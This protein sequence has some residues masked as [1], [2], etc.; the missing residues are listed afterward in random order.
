MILTAAET[1]A[2]GELADKLLDE[3]PD[4]SLELRL[5]RIGVLAHAIPER[6]RTVLTQFRING[7]PYGGFVISG[8][9]IDESLA[10]ATPSGY[11]QEPR[12]RE[13]ERAAA[14]L[15]LIG[16]VLGDPFSYL[17]QQRGRMVLDVF[18]VRGHESSQLGSSSTTVLEWHNEDAFHPCRADWIMLICMRNRDG[19]A[20]MFGPVQELELSPETRETLFQERFI[21]KPDESH[22]EEFNTATTGIEADPRVVEAFGRVREMNARP[23][24]LSVL[25]GDRRAPYVR[26]DPAFMERELG[27]VPAER[28][29]EEIIRQFDT[30]VRDVVLAPGELLI[31]DNLRAVHGRRPFAARYDGTD[32]WLRRINV[33]ADLRKSADRRFGTHGRAVI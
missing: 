16:S 20:T 30:R 24:R 27:D 1:A 9:P 22:T 28:A 32:R 6:I 15:F 12:G 10:G 21:I 2:V 25:S 13:V 33:T 19:V 3:D 26:I 17:T 7:E 11:Q 8:L 31:I 4:T 14:V 29:L 18:P 5:P 23:Q